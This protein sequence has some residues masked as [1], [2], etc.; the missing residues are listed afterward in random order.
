MPTSFRV[1][2]PSTKVERVPPVVAMIV[3]RPALCSS[4][5]SV[6]GLTAMAI[7]PPARSV[8]DSAEPR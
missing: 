5:A 2:T 4:S 8:I 6:T 1:G 7:W 3:T